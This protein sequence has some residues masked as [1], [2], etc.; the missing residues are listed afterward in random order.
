MKR[1][2]VAIRLP[3]AQQEDL[4]ALVERMRVS[5]REVR[6]LKRGNFHLTLR[7]LGE[8]SE[9]FLDT[10]GGLL[11]PICHETAPFTL[12][13]RDTGAFPSLRKPSVLWA[14]A[15]G[16]DA[17]VYL[18]HSVETAAVHCGSVPEP[19]PFHPHVTL[20]RIRARRLTQHKTPAP[21]PPLAFD[22]G[23]FEVNAVAL[24]ESTLQ[25]GGA[26]HTLLREFSFR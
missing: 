11:E 24:F 23:A 16:S 1:A 13:L 2:F 3:D 19:R 14:G 20:G 6:W 21:A 8:V 9:A 22:G 7:F 15:T 25:R 18:Q 5:Y 26:V 10:F 17:L 12:Y 4:C